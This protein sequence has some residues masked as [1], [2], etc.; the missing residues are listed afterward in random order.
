V[1]LR[2]EAGFSSDLKW[3]Q[4]V[5]TIVSKAAPCLHYLKQLKWAGAPTTDLLHF[6]TTVMRQVL[7]ESVQKRAIRVVNADWLQNCINLCRY[8]QSTG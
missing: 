7:E 3:A 2:L 6:Y 4:H 8:W 5:D 1:K